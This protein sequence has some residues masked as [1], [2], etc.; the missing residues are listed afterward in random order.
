MFFEYFDRSGGAGNEFLSLADIASAT[1]TSR[2]FMSSFDVATLDEEMAG[3]GD[4]FAVTFRG[5][6]VIQTAGFYTFTLY[7]DDG[8]DLWI[9]GEQI[10]NHDGLHGAT[11]QTVSVMLYPGEIELSGSYF[12]HLG[13][14]TLEITVMGPGVPDGP[15]YPTEEG[16]PPPP[17]NAGTGINIFDSGLLGDPNGHSEVQPYFDDLINGGDGHDRLEGNEGHDTLNGGADDDTLL[18]DEG[19]DVLSGDDGNDQLFGGAGY[20]LLNGGNGDDTLNGGADDDTVYGGDGNDVL[21]GGTGFNVLDGGSGNDTILAEHP[22]LHSTL[23]TDPI[24]QSAIN[25]HAGHLGCR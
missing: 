25:G 19:N 24:S 13:D 1:Q 5:M 18:G 21:S 10:I 3:D 17:S 15:V 9:N 22:D 23:L 2:G 7:S 16:D 20:D 12:E 4:D 14:E 6:L 11:T 8:S